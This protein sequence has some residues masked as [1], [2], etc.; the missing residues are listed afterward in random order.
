M[1]VV[2]LVVTGIRTDQHPIYEIGEEG[3]V[4]HLPGTT[5]VE[6]A[7]TTGPVVATIELLWPGN[8]ERPELDSPWT[9]TDGK[10]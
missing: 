8:L 7:S 1:T 9:L 5:H 10:S 6:L 4:D 2:P 3:P